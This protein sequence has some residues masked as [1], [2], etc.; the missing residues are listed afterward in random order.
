MTLLSNNITNFNPE[1][2]LT[3]TTKIKKEISDEIL[4]EDVTPFLEKEI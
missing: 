1:S 2:F 4:D 3:T